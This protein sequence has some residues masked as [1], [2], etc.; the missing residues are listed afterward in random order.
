MATRCNSTSSVSA[1]YQDARMTSTG[2]PLT[3]H[4]DQPRA[5]LLELAG[6]IEPWDDLERVR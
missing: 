3:D 4:D 1:S 5:H 2:R 6:A